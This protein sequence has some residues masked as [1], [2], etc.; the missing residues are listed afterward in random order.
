MLT[1]EGAELRMFC[2]PRAKLGAMVEL[3]GID[4]GIK[5]RWKI[6]GFR[7]SLDN[8]EGTFTTELDLR[9]LA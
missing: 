2:E 9:E 3:L 8:W 5:G 4:T 1:D 7:H 6:V